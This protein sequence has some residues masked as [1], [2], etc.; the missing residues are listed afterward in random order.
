MR[1]DLNMTLF[2]KIRGGV[3]PKSN[4]VA[5]VDLNGHFIRWL[6]RKIVHRHKLVYRSINVLVFHPDDGSL[7]VQRRQLD[8]VPNGGHWD[9]SVA[10]HVD[11]RD[12]PFGD[13][14]ADVMAFERSAVRELQ[15]EIGINVPLSLINIFGPQRGIHHEYLALYRC[16]SRGPFTPQQSEVEALKWITPSTLLTLSPRTKHLNWMTESILGWKQP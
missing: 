7:L 10:G 15:E 5:H 12:H 8:K 16:E 11:Y 4:D 6:D 13:P 2:G 14:N 9:I 3:L 1:A